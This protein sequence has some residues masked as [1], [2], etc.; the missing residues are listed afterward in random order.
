MRTAWMLSAGAAILTLAATTASAQQRIARGR[1]VS[2]DVA[3]KVWIPA[4]TVRLVGWDRDS[5][6]VE[7]M[8]TG[9]ERFFFGGDARGIKFGVEEPPRD[10]IAQPAELVVHLPK[11]ARVS[12]KTVSADIE[13]T[14]VSGWFTAVGGGIRISGQAREVQAEALDG[15]VE[16][17]VTAPWVRARTGSGPLTIGGAVEDLAA[18]TVSGNLSVS[19]RGI[20]RG[21]F[22]SV[23]GRIVFSAALA[24]GGAVD[25][26]N[27]SGAV[28]IQLPSNIAADVE[29]TTVAGSITNRF[30]ARRPI[31]GRQG[32]GQDLA[33]ATDP[34]GAR[35]A[36]RTFKGPI[37]LERR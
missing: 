26:D 15:A 35:V 1:A 33:F 16:L 36:A 8:V 6:S 19:S 34:N 2:R 5:L 11:G 21:K 22:D 32:R 14:D 4:G 23:T 3:V 9:G 17:N 10:R 37:L 30:D 13:A 24:R 25:F 18:S 27:H 7:G 20:E 31:A 12:V 29:L 28:E